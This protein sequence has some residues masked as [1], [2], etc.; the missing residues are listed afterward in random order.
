MSAA[1]H[2][3]LVTNSKLRLQPRLTEAIGKL[4]SVSRA[5]T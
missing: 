1:R 3:C 2:I 5:D 4:N